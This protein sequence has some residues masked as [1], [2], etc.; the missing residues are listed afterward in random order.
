MAPE[1]GWGLEEDSKLKL[2]KGGWGVWGDYSGMVLT[3]VPSIFFLK[4]TRRGGS[5]LG[6]R[7]EDLRFVLLWLPLS[8]IYRILLLMV[9]S[10][11]I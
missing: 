8:W 4:K 1:S 6:S 10:S 5:S 7:K 11:T 9:G 2:A 3:G